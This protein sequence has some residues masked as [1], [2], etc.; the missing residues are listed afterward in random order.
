MKSVVLQ[1]IAN[2]NT[3]YLYILAIIIHILIN[4]PG[5]TCEKE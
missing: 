5:T 1:L 3:A 4:I 2:Q